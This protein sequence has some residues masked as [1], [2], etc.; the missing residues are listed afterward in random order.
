MQPTNLGIT[1]LA[2]SLPDFK[3]LDDFDRAIFDGLCPTISPDS[4][5]PP[6]AGQVVKQALTQSGIA[7]SSKISILFLTASNT[8]LTLPGFTSVAISNVATLSIALETASQLLQTGAAQAVVLVASSK[9]AAAALV[10]EQ[11]NAR[12]YA[13][14]E[15]W[16]NSGNTTQ[17]CRDACNS[18]GIQTNQIE[19]LEVAAGSEASSN[20]A[21]NAAFG[22]TERAFT[23]GLGSLPGASS[24]L[25]QLL[26]LIK[27]TLSLHHRYI[28]ANPSFPSDT[29]S[30]QIQ[31][32]IERK[33]RAHGFWKVA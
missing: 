5:N 14:I 7:L 13:K 24:L 8:A 32:S 11:S 31:L 17:A 30:G 1:G 27:V 19:Y 21:L 26:G 12:E 10:I 22:V 29:D 9:E 20:V 23:C 18:A 33:N 3:E 4:L 28:P 15:G 2:A 25:A 16:G 6:L